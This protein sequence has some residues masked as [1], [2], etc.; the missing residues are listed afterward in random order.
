MLGESATRDNGQTVAL[1]RSRFLPV[2]ASEMAGWRDRKH[3]IES[4][5]SVAA[6]ATRTAYF[7]VEVLGERN[8]QVIARDCRR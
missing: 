8:V 2:V 3:G 6:R 1:Q 5:D 4:V 7:V